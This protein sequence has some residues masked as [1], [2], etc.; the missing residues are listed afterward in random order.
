M[1][2][3]KNLFL[4]ILCV[5]L[6][7]PLINFNFE[8][9]YAS[10]IDNRMLTEWDIHSE[11][12]T[13]MADSYIKDRIGFRTEAIDTYTELHDKVY[14]M[15]IHPTYT[16]GKDGY[17]FFQMAFESPE[18]TFFDLFC[19]YLRK[20]Q[21]YCEERGVPFFYCLNPSKITVYQQHLPRG[22]QYLDKVNQ[23]MYKKL[24][25][26]GVNYITNEELLIEKSKTEQVYNVKYD[27]GHWNDLGAFYGSNHILEKVGEYFPQVRPKEMSDF[28]IGEITQTSLPV[29]HFKIN[30]SVPAFLDKNSDNI[31]DVTENYRSLKLDKNYDALY[32]LRNH[33]EGA[34]NLPKVLVFQGS[35]YNGRQQYF[36]SAFR[37]YNG[38][39]NYENFLNFDYYFNV[40]QPDCVILETAEY[41]TNGAYFSYE[42]LEQKELNPKLDIEKYQEQMMNLEN[43]DYTL[44]EQ[45]NLL[46]LSVNP[47]KR[48][49]EDILL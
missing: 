40:F 31:E 25:E 37:Q 35:Y 11:D 45:G 39:H 24:E 48:Q 17:V 20:V 47:K 38:V 32:C 7:L 23:M 22:Y 49:N 19:S 13:K 6:L 33:G 28:E 9:D 36:Q 15:M 46:T 29:S 5:A 2:K 3:I 26:Y 44:E 10:P 1:R 18:P 12:F 16:Y 41:A 43:V 21:D 30:E 27:A 14:G 34:E 42:T 8:K 4:I